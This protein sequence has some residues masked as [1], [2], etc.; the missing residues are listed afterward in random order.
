MMLKKNYSHKLQ[1]LVTD[2]GQ[3]LIFVIFNH[4]DYCLEYTR[5]LES[6]NR[7]THTIYPEHCLVISQQG[8]N[9]DLMNLYHLAVVSITCRTSYL[10]FLLKAIIIHASIAHELKTLRSCLSLGCTYRSDQ[11][12]MR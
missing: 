4:Q 9:R 8:L 11:Q 2:N 10:Y 1:N 5:S 3:H 12:A 7:F 6:K